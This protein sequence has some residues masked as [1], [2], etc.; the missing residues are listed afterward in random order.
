[1]SHTPGPWKY[2]ATYGLIMTLFLGDHIFLSC[3]VD[4]FIHAAPAF[5][6]C[7]CLILRRYWA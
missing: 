7:V 1:M 3:L 2:D 6:V 5:G 4:T